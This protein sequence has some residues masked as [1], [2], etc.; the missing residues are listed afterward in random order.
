METRVNYIRTKTNSIR[1]S[2]TIL[3]QSKNNSVYKEKSD[4]TTT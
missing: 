2:S 4:P 3:V 1:I